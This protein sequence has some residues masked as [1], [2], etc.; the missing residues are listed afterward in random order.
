M[1]IGAFQGTLKA[2]LA[3]PHIPNATLTMLDRNAQ[4]SGGREQSHKNSRQL[5]FREKDAGL[6]R[7]LSISNK[8]KNMAYK[9]PPYSLGR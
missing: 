5:K 9:R 3:F 1:I 8:D 2:Y 7:R 6:W 4:C